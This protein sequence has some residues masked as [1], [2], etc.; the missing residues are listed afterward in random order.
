[1]D[2]ALE[3]L[4]TTIIPTYRRPLLLRRAI[5]SALEQTERRIVVHVFDNDSNDATTDV[6]R[7]MQLR[8]SRI[9]YTIRPH[10]I[11]GAANIASATK[12]IETPFFSILCDDDVL[13]PS[14]YELARTALDLHADAMMYASASLV[15]DA[16]GK[17]IAARS[18]ING[19][20]KL[21]SARSTAL[22]VSGRHPDFPAAFFRTNVL[23]HVGGFAPEAGS[24]LDVDL[25]IRI[26]SR[27]PVVF[28][29]E[30]G[31]ILV[32]HEESWSNNVTRAAA[33][34]NRLIEEM[35]SYVPQPE[36]ADALQKTLRARRDLRTLQL[37]FRAFDIGTQV[38]VDD[39][40][41]VLRDSGSTRVA[42]LLS[43][44]KRVNRAIPIGG[45]IL[46]TIALRLK[47]LRFVHMIQ[48][49]LFFKTSNGP[50]YHRQLAHFSRL[51]DE[52]RLLGSSKP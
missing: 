18:G 31:G 2:S 10:N 22:M 1:M 8:D 52:T 16:Q 4:I 5:L 20:D 3:A 13:L 14:F 21:S 49:S 25:Y 33:E 45:F 11:G 23:E 44:L 9:R 46:A 42:D 24:L 28:S 41:H 38:E 32:D 51:T 47:A 48:S 35:N 6:V 34:Y 39:F 17:L 30:P 50:S 37:A 27:Y 15:V 36:E 29:S 12:E 43:L 7:E 19:T 40:I 26:A